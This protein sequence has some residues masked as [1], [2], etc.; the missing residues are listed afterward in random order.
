MRAK[1][2]AVGLAMGRDYL[3]IP[4]ICL[5]L[6]LLF[7]VC[8]TLPAFAQ[9][10]G[11]QGENVCDARSTVQ[12]VDSLIQRHQE[13]EA[14]L[15]LQRVQ[16]CPQLS[17]IAKFNIAWT[18]GRLHDFRTALKIFATVDPNV[19]NLQTHAY[20]VALG[21][22]ELKD[23]SSAVK[24]LQAV[25]KQQALDQDCANLLAVVYAKQGQYQDAYG[26]LRTQLQEHPKDLISYLNMITLLS[27]AGQFSEAQ[28]V[29]T[30]G[31]AVFPHN[32][33]M[34]IVRGATETLLGKLDQAR[35]DFNNAV[36]ISP[37]DPNPRFFLALTDYRLTNYVV[38]AADL[39]SAMGSGV[40]SPDL[41]YLL[42]ECMLK[43]HP[44]KPA[45]AIAELDKAIQLDANSVPARTLRGKLLLEA[46]DTQKAIVD[47]QI[48]HK[49]DP[50]MRSAA[51]NLARAYFAVGKQKQ[52]QV[53]YQ[54]IQT[55]TT[56]TVTELGNRR[57]KSV[58]SGQP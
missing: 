47:L 5:T 31:V 56:D 34:L 50:T 1:A 18:Y 19:P 17:Q 35:I 46:G 52:A 39:R 3:N 53:L 43:L 13:R 11:R 20:A 15:L 6:A 44:T 55:Q 32:S 57:I 29:A 9:D 58:L 41:E 8:A 30:A 40:V 42:A 27:D 37:M 38:A 23:Y 24:T 33:E 28:K 26:I 22:F 54:Q 12:R 21:Q 49:L 25:Q 14:R 45:E 10:V 7:L 2:R 51:Y 4:R 36:K 16:A 48:A